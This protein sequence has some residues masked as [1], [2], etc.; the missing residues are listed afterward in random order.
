MI[1]PATSE[2]VSKGPLTPSQIEF[3]HKTGYLHL[4]GLFDSHRV[5]RFVSECERLV[6]E[7]P[8]VD[9][10]NLRAQSRPNVEG[11]TVFDRFDPINDI[12]PVFEQSACDPTLVAAIGQLFAD[13]ALLFKDKLIFKRPGTH[14]YRIHQDYTYWCEL[15]SPPEAM[16]SVL[17]AI[18]ASSAENGALEIYPGAHHKHIGPAE[19]PHD[20]FD[21]NSGLLSED[22]MKGIEPTMLPLSPGDALVFHSLAPH[23][24][25]INHGTTSRRSLYFSYSAARYGD[26]YDIY[27]KNFH[28]YLRSD[29]ADRADKLYF[30]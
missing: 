19:K 8:D 13:K 26:L 7:Y 30:R 28:G 5:D 3:Y 16:L 12:S 23:R 24:S 2:T 20:I 14:G 6:R 29:R 11:K 9:E 27:Y 4:K 17:I 25:G 1:R 22:Q 18:D 10:S 15:P 21:P